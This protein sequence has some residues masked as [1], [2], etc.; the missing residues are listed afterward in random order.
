MIRGSDAAGRSRRL[1]RALGSSRQ[2]SGPQGRSDLQRRD[3]Q[4]HRHRR[5]CSRSP[6]RSRISSRRRSA[7]CCSSA[8]TLEEAGLLGSRYYVDASGVS[9][10]QDRRRHQH[11]CAADPRADEGHRGHRLGPVASSTTTSRTRPPRRTA[12]S[13]RTRRRRKASSSA[14]I[15]ST[16]RGSACRCCMRDR[17]ST[18][19][20]AAKKPDASAYADYTANRYHKPADEYDPNWDFRGVIEDLRGVL[21][22]RQASSPT[23]RRSRNGSP[24]P[25][26]IGRLPRARSRRRK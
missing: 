16:S 26:S 17:D 19:S 3:R 5:R 6:K 25:I 8:V 18:S 15:S 10:R 1:Q 21:R 2:G 23:R 9:A 20:T 7:R 14:P 13:C 4:R 24:T 12:R 22:G 11:G